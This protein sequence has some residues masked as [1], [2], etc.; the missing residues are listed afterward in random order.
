MEITLDQSAG[1]TIQSY[2]VGRITIGEKTYTTSLIVTPEKILEWPPLNFNE[3]S[4]EYLQSIKDLKPELV[5]IGSGEQQKMLS[6]EFLA[7]F[8][9]AGIGIECMTTAAACRT[10]NLLVSEARN[11]AVGLIQL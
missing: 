8:G 1:N 2:D 5:I 10:Y 6:A 9:T 4:L 11:V 3:L 7:F